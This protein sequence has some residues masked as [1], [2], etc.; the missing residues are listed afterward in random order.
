MEAKNF[1]IGNLVK[2][3]NGIYKIFAMS[4]P[5][6]LAIQKYDEPMD[7]QL[8]VYPSDNTIIEPIELTK[9]WLLKCGG[10]LEPIDEDNYEYITLEMNGWNLSADSSNN[11]TTLE[12]NN[13]KPVRYIHE[14]QNLFLRLLAQNFNLKTNVALVANYYI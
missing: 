3:G 11:F 4:I 1:R 8:N 6:I 10:K 13:F 14:L 5:Q 12:N 9:D 2:S 7:S